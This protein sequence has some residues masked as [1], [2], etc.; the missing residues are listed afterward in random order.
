[1]KSLV[2]YFRSIATNPTGSNRKAVLY[3]P[4]GS[5]KTLVT[6]VFE[7]DI[8]NY[9]K[10]KHQPRDPIFRY[11]HVNCRKTKTPQLILTT[12]LRELVPGFPLRGFSVD[13]LL[14]MFTLLLVEQNLV[15]LLVLDE[16]DFDYLNSDERNDLLYQLC[17]IQERPPV[18]NN[19][20]H[21][22]GSNTEARFNLL[23]ITSNPNLPY[24]LDESS[25]SSF[26]RKLSFFLHTPKNNCS[27]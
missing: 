8:T 4:V 9:I 26:D 18:L 5:G 1:M 16:I 12:V 11:F 19:S 14:R 2:N 23:I 27:I 24:Y 10:K 13:E 17:C 15:V 25:T 22:S 21:S 6:R 20:K 3:G 7:Q